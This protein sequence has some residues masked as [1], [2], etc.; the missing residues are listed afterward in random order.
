VLRTTTGVEAQSTTGIRAITT[1]GVEAQ[2]TTGIRAIT[3]TSIE[4]KGAGI[5]AGTTTGRDTVAR[6]RG[7]AIHL[8]LP[9]SR[10]K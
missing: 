7:A 2:S 5:E 1:T 6:R 10:K 4:Q 3:I 9:K 8:E